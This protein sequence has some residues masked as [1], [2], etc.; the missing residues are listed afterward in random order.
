MVNLIPG[1][2]DVLPSRILKKYFSIPNSNFVRYGVSDDGTCFFH[3]I[4]AAMNLSNYHHRS[5]QTKKKIGRNLR[6]ILQRTMNLDTWKEFWEA[7]GISIKKVPNVRS[8]IKKMKNPSQ[9]SD[10]F[11]I[12]YVMDSLGL[13]MIFFDSKTNSMYCGVRGKG[14]AKNTVFILWVNR[15]HFEPIFSIQKDNKVTT[16]FKKG[17]PIVG[18]VMNMYSKSSCPD[19]TLNSVL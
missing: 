1:K 17:N 14:D 15:A 6:R 12:I 11:M 16:I 8:V 9:W 4:A 18:H 5:L 10:I 7:R 3:S 2:V 19:V 13:N